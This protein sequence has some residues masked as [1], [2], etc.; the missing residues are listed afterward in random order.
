ARMTASHFDE[1]AD[2]YD[3][4]I[5]AHVAEHYLR[6]RAAF[7]VEH[8]PRGRLLDV[9]CGTGVLALRLAELGYDVVG[10]DPSEGM[11]E[12]M[13]RRAPGVQA[14]QGSGTE[15]PFADGEFDVALSVATMHHIAEPAA[16]RATLREMARVTK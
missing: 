15:L 8:C 9:G 13:R 3:E 16:V 10:L 7:V 6:K 1:V 5:P 14:V 12:V 11:L 4:T 2:S